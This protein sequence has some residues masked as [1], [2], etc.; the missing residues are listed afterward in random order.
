MYHRRSWEFY[1]PEVQRKSVAIRVN[2]EEAL[3]DIAN[4]STVKECLGDI[5]G[6]AYYI[7]ICMDSKAFLYKLNKKWATLQVTA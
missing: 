6:S 3:E 2:P 4:A 1:V 7:A 5:I